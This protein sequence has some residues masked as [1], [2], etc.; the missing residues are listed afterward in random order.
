MRSLRNIIYSYK[1]FARNFINFTNFKNRLQSLIS[2][3][4]KEANFASKL[5]NAQKNTV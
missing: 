1:Y 4:A 3:A 5:P 2:C